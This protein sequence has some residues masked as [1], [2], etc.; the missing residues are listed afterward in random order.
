[1]D[2]KWIRTL[3][4]KVARLTP[5]QARQILADHAKRGPHLGDPAYKE[6]TGGFSSQAIDGTVSRKLGI[7]AGYINRK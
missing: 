7:K 6:L 1:M 5:E 2:R 3:A 4:Q